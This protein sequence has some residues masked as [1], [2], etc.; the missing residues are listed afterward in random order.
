MWGSEA[1]FRAAG[2]RASSS[3]AQT[4]SEGIV[5][6]YEVLGQSHTPT[7]LT[8]SSVALDNASMV[9]QRAIHLL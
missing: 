4:T 1:D 6:E 5:C 9:G 7:S 3:R 2:D 8:S